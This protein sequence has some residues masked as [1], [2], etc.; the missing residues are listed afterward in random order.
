MTERGENLLALWNEL[1]GLTDQKDSV[2]VSTVLAVLTVTLVL[3]GLDG[4][5]LPLLLWSL[6]PGAA[7]GML[8]ARDVR[9]A[10]RRREI[11]IEIE[12]SAEGS[13]RSIGPA[14]PPSEKS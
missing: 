4:G 8:I 13:P 11:R 6:I 9:R 7:A 10:L 12:G 1:D 5:S 14:A 2:A 3:L